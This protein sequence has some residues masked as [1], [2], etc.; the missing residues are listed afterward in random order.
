[1]TILALAVA[2]QPPPRVVDDRL[3]S[4]R[5]TVEGH[6][7]F[8]LSQAGARVTATAARSNTGENTRV[9][10][11]RAR[12]VPSADQQ[13]C[14]TW[15]G[16]LGDR[17]QR[18]AA[19]RVRTANGRTRAITVTH[20]V[21]FNARW[22]FN[23][24]VMDSGAA[25]PFHKIGG[26][27]LTEVFRPG[28]PGTFDVPPFP[29]RLCARV[30]GRVVSFIVWPTNQPQPAWDDPR[31]GGSVLLPAGWDQ[32]GEAGWY[33]GHLRAGEHATFQDLVAVTVRTRPAAPSAP[34]AG[35]TGEGVEPLPPASPPRQPTWIAEAP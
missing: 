14:A 15:V 26:F 18:G 25:E 35:R 3:A 13:T 10:F 6:D 23:I 20:N 31:Y 28:G 4:S 27:E 8:V 9:A 11:W 33:I 30:V 1:M 34:G 5:L 21:F 16:P 32:P 29:W 2:C 22:G 19:L 24:H 12:H 7:F 17:E